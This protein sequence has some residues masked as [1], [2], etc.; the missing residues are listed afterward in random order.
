MSQTLECVSRAFAIREIRRNSFNVYYSVLAN[1]CEATVY[2]MPSQWSRLAI[3]KLG[4][5]CEVNSH[6][7]VEGE[8]VRADLDCIPNLRND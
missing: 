3:E 1:G 6:L 5:W 8:V 7:L 4:R 2:I